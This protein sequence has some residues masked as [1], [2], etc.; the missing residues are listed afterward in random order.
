MH[1]E[2]VDEKTYKSVISPNLSHQFNSAQFNALNS[3]KCDKVHYLLFFEEKYRMGIILG[4]KGRAFL[5]PFSAPFGG[6]EAVRQDI[7]VYLLE[8]AVKLTKE[9][10]RENGGNELKIGLPPLF[11]NQSVVS[12]TINCLFRHDFNLEV[13]DLNHTVNL[14]TWKQTAIKRRNDFSEMK[15]RLCADVEEK[16]AAY[17]VIKENRKFKGYPLR[18][19]LEQVMETITIIQADFFLVSNPKGQN[20][21]AA[22]VFHVAKGIVQV[23]YWGNLPGFDDSRP[24]NFLALS[25]FEYYKEQGL[26]MIDIGPS[27]EN[28]EPNYGLCD[29]KERIGCEV[30]PKFSFLWINSDDTEKI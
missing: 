5:S 12:K 8:N 25:L 7:P 1:I 17:E 27:S 23:I 28:S 20:I 16:I 26:Q 22:L 18:M 6:F 10:V 24:M 13:V 21:A 2:Q 3:G 4:Q 19:T 30:H 14:S 9:Y 29:F 15:F 11:Y